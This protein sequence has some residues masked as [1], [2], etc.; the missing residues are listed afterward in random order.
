L[1][2][3]HT[4]FERFL[5]PI[6][7]ASNA[8]I[9]YHYMCSFNRN[10]SCWHK[11]ERNFQRNRI[12]FSPV[13]VVKV[14]KTSYLALCTLLDLFFQYSAGILWVLKAKLSYIFVNQVME[15]YHQ[16]F[17]SWRNI[18]FPSKQRLLPWVYIVNFM[19]SKKTAESHFNQEKK[20]GPLQVLLKDKP[21]TNK[22]IGA[23]RVIC[24]IGEKSV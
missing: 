19:C 21:T 24:M 12:K 2:F 10:F 6:Y 11:F 8:K 5:F 4:I 7:L 14:I 18:F 9:L 15:V 17:W 13:E 16:F 22:F 1:D 3:S 20:W 23:F